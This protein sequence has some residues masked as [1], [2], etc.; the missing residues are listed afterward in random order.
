MLIEAVNDLFRKYGKSRPRSK[1]RSD[2]LG[3]GLRF[4]DAGADQSCVDVTLRLDRPGVLLAP[5]SRCDEYVLTL[6]EPMLR[7]M[8][9]SIRRCA[10]ASS[11]VTGA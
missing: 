8:S 6:R 9:V 7:R 10:A 1:R 5:G 4:L 3:A 2:A 11:Y